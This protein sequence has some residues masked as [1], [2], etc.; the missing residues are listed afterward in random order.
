VDN[1][2]G[3]RSITGRLGV[4]NT[5]TASL[6]P[7]DPVASDD[8]VLRL[9][10]MLAGDARPRERML[11]LT[12]LDADDRLL[13]LAIPV[14]GIPALPDDDVAPGLGTLV[15]SVVQEAA[16]GGS[17]VAVLERPGD[18]TITSADRAWN[19]VLREQSAA[20]GVRVRGVFLAAS[21]L[22]RP[23]TLDDAG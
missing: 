15:R 10:R 21:G 7:G 19:A 2:R 5:S 18:V 17:V 14:R 20:G 22:V 9:A 6:R 4:V 11:L 3:G 1:F 23:V 8:D 16:P 12:W 13:G